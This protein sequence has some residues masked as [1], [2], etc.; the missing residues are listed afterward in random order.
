MECAGMQIRPFRIPHDCAEGFG[1]RIDTADGRC[2]VFCTDL[3]HI[4]ETVQE[5]IY[6]CDAIVMESN[7]DIGMLRQGSYPYYL[8]QR[9]LSKLGHL[10]NEVCAQ[11]LPKLA[12]KGTT[13]FLLAHLSAENNTPRA[14]Y[15]ASISALTDAG[16]QQNMDFQLA[17]APRDNVKGSMWIF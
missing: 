6:G 7:H 11:E 8:K 14:A 1:Y 3:G 5:G 4:P 2:V 13:R 16:L 10:S 15:E 9:I 12:Q 17:V